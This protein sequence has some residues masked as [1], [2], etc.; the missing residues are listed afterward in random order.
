M[1]DDIDLV[2]IPPDIVIREGVFGLDGLMLGLVHV[3]DAGREIVY[4]LQLSRGNDHRGAAVEAWY[5]EGGIGF[6]ILCRSWKFQ[7]SAKSHDEYVHM[8][9]EDSNLGI[10]IIGPVSRLVDGAKRGKP[11]R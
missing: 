9:E 11:P 3:Q 7:R 1:A 8:L 10:A 2:A 5:E 4:F 6:G